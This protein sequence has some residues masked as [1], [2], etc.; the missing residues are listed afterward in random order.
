MVTD[1]Y[2]AGRQLKQLMTGSIMREETE[3]HLRGR[4]AQPCDERFLKK[5]LNII[6]RQTIKEGIR[7]FR[8]AG[9]VNEKCQNI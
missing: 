7:S 5:N 8:M 9:Y 2:G 3:Q 1:V 6:I 4:S